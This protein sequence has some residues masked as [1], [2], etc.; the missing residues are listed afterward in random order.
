MYSIQFKEQAMLPRERL[1]AEGAE[2][3]SN[4]EL[5]AICLRTGTK[6]EH[7]LSLANSI[8]KNLS[9]L[10][11]LRQLSLEE[12]QNISGIGR[13]KSIELKAMIELA[14]RIQTAE[15]E[16]QER[17]MSS[18]RLARRMMLEL[19]DK[20][21]E[22][23]VALYLDTQN[24]LIAQ[25]TIFIGTVRRSVAEPREILHYA[26]KHM[27]TSL[28]VIHNHPS[29]VTEPSENDFHFTDKLKRCCD[30]LGVV[31]LDHLI[32]GRNEYFSFREETDNL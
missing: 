15:V 14:N 6:K 28:I 11:D 10:A 24:R 8:L 16:K 4:Q 3:L 29:G 12:L 21:Q 19:G 23:L 5:L 13:V 22:H 32:V 30:D 1:S 9:S 7:V 2:H 27:A 31:F 26:C 25:K 20:K 17:I 18:E